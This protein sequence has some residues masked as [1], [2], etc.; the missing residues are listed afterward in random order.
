MNIEDKREKKVTVC[1][2]TI[3]GAEAFQYNN[4][5]YMKVFINDVWNAINL[6]DGIGYFF[7]PD[8][9]VIPLD[10]KIVIQK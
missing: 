7:M 9:E 5:I 3:K 1:L 2:S 8:T 6:S 4:D 10:A